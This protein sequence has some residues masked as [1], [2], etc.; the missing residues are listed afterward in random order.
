M[1]NSKDNKIETSMLYH[2]AIKSIILIC[3]M[4]VGFLATI[5]GIVILT[6][7]NDENVM[8]N[9]MYI[10]LLLY[11]IVPICI[12]LLIYRKEKIKE[13]LSLKKI[14]ITNIF[15]VIALHITI[16]PLVLFTNALSLVFTDNV[17]S[18]SI[19]SM[20]FNYLQLFLIV[21]IVGPILEEFIFRGILFNITKKMK[22]RYMA[23]LSGFLFG[24]FHMNLNQFSYAFLLGAVF[25]IYVAYTGSILSAIISHII[26]NSFSV[27]VMYVTEIAAENGL[28][29][30]ISNESETLSNSEL[31]VFAIVAGV[32][33]LLF[34]LILKFFKSYNIENNENCLY[35]KNKHI[36]ENTIIDEI[37][38]D[39][40]DEIL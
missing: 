13:I 16:L 26:L 40:I 24:A 5:A 11:E 33:F 19:E 17:I 25:T 29:D 38:D 21:G 15:F 34:L 8:G 22:L 6:L 27:L 10:Q 39:A 9:G 28:Y 31:G 32:F 37:N 12:Y 7:S 23:I 18:E 30:A 1:E 35:Y 14:S 2:P 3:L 20:N 36:E 4:F